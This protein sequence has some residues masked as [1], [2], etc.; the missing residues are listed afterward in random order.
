VSARALAAALALGVAAPAGAVPYF[1]SAPLLPITRLPAGPVTTGDFNGDGHRDVAY[2]IHNPTGVAVLLGDGQGRYGRPIVSQVA[3]QTSSSAEALVAADL[4]GD[5]HLDLVLADFATGP[6]VYLGLGDGRFS[7]QSLGGEPLN[8]GLAVGDFDGDGARDL[9]LT[10]RGFTTVAQVLVYRGNGSGGFGAPLVWSLP[11]LLL[12]AGAVARDFDGDGRDDIAVAD[13]FANGVAILLG[14][15]TL[16]LNLRGPFA[17]GDGPLGID[18][19]DLDGDG[20]WDVAVANQRARTVAIMRG[21]G[22]GSLGAPLALPAPADTRRVLLGHFDGDANLDVAVSGLGV[23]TYRG[24]GAGGGGSVRRYGVSGELAAADLTADGRLDLVAGPSLL[25]GDGAGGFAAQ[26]TFPTG[27]GAQGGVAADFDRDGNTDVAVA[28]SAGSVAVLRGDGQGAFAAPLGVLTGTDV[29]DVATA[30]FDRDGWPDLAVAHRGTQDVVV[31]RNNQAGGFARQAYPVGGAPQSLALGDF[32]GDG[33]IDIAVTN[34]TAGALLVLHGGGDGTF[35]PGGTTLV[36]N[37]SLALAAGR[38]NDDAR[39]DLAWF[40]APL[41][42]NLQ[43]RLLLGTGQETFVLGPPNG[44]YASDHALAAADLNGDGRLDLVGGG[45]HQPFPEPGG[46]GVRLGDGQGGFGGPVYQP[47]VQVSGLAVR[48]FTGDGTPDVA[49]F[50][51]STVATGVRLLRGGADGVLGLLQEPTIPVGSSGRSL[52][53][54][55]FDADGRP[56]LAALAGPGETMTVLLAR[57]AG[58]GT[59]LRI[60]VSGTPDPVGGGQTV[61]YTATVS[62]AGPLPATAVR[63]RLRVPA[64]LDYLGHT[65]LPPLCAMAASVVSCD[66]PSLAAG[67]VFVLSVDAAAA[68]TGGGQPTG[69]ADVRALAPDELEPRDNFAVV[70]T[71]VNPVDLRIAA[72]DSA[73][74]VAPGQ[75]FRY[76]LTVVNEGAFRATRVLAVAELPHGVTLVALP[77]PSCFSSDGRVVTCGSASLFP[78]QVRTF[79][80]DVRAATFTSVVLSARVEADQVDVHPANDEV[81]EQTLMRLALRG[82]LSHG[83]SRRLRLSPGDPAEDR[84][85]VRV[86][87]RSAFE[88]V[89]DEGSGDL[90]GAQPVALERLGEDTSSVVQVGAALGTG[91]ARTLRWQNSSAET[92]THLVRVRSR[93][94]TSD[95]GLDDTYRLRAWDATGSFARFNTTHD[96]EVVILVQNPAAAGVVN[97]T[98]WFWRG[99]GALLAT[100]P[101]SLPARRSLV[102]QVASLLP[103]SAGSIT[104]T[105]DAGY[106]GLVGKAVAIEPA[107]GFS[108]DTPLV[109]RPR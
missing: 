96:Q 82:E 83:A 78:R 12:P 84:F 105:H 92:E 76:T 94:C 98:L 80:I 43:T 5:P 65:P 103:G 71:V 85:V 3:S 36:G 50:E 25:A 44:L 109:A 59:D 13:N 97:G 34:E 52:V 22:T 2:A 28:L 75:D 108:Y 102:L 91:T 69:W 64:G 19:G 62:N 86:P 48:D 107:T 49:V 66:L 17:A 99:D 55:D 16:A 51:S 56:D 31:L 26:R 10:H 33:G 74:P 37:G 42:A 58:G 30:D 106:A 1:S 9:A 73:D 81:E 29:V 24:D 20:R 90:D 61:H 88:V 23:W 68:A 27:P 46:L 45:D 6:G 7:G 8:Q 11:T 77:D 54:G 18:A 72:S 40:R 67:A 35:V 57:D 104:L 60:A 41:S 87:A 89:M 47:P 38:F 32:G 100:R 53:A 14:S 63:V 21:D 39:E 79:P 101:F 70:R 4:N 93:G 95:C 15:P